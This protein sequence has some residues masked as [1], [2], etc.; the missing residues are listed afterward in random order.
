MIPFCLLTILSTAAATPV[1]CYAPAPIVWGYY[2]MMTVVCLSVCLSRAAV[3]ESKSKTE[4]L[5]KIKIGRREVHD[6]GDA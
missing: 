6:T 2:A 5:S 1:V 3:P 4:V